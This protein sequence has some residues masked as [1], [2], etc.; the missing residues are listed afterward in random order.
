MTQPPRVKFARTHLALKKK[1]IYTTALNLRHAGR[2]SSMP[3]TPNNQRLAY[4]R[5]PAA[6]TLLALQESKKD[7]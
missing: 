2:P 3:Q 7:R 1:T 5:D 6:A 4:V